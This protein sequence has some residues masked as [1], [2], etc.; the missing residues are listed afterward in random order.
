MK[1]YKLNIGSI[2]EDLAINI[3][4][5][6]ALEAIKAQE[7]EEAREEAEEERKEKE[8]LKKEEKDKE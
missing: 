7:K 5:D 2:E 1:H 4:E 3:M 8:K 6:D